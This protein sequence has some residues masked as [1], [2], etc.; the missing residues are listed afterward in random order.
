MCVPSAIRLEKKCMDKS[1]YGCSK[2]CKWYGNIKKGVC[3]NTYY[4]DKDLALEYK[5]VS[6]EID[7]FEKFKNILS[8]RSKTIVFSITDRVNNINKKLKMLLEKEKKINVKDV[9]LKESVFE[10]N[11]ETLKRLREE[12]FRLNKEKLKLN[13]ILGKINKK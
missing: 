10:K 2:P 6:S 5:L 3:R 4:N 13:S 9:T 11:M 1:F 12:E 7:R 8:N